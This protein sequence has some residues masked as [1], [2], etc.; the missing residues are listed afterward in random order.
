MKSLRNESQKLRPIRPSVRRC[1]GGLR[2]APS[3]VGVLFSKTLSLRQCDRARHS[4]ATEHPPRHVMGVGVHFRGTLHQH[5]P[6]IPSAADFGSVLHI[7]SGFVR[8][9]DGMRQ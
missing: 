1:G 5:L 9:V 6:F 4:W 8:S 2:G 7:I 3:G